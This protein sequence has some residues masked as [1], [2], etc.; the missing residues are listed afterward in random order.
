MYTKSLTQL[1]FDDVTTR[2]QN[3]HAWAPLISLYNDNGLYVSNLLNT[4]I[5]RK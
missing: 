3:S 5:L 1:D 4:A 2:R